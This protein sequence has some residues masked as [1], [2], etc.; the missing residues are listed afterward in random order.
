MATKKPREFEHQG[1]KVELI[2]HR[3]KVQVWVEGQPVTG[4][5]YYKSIRS[6]RAAALS[7]ITRHPEKFAA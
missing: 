3:T 1:A 5:H 4:L 7:Y 2:G 6:A